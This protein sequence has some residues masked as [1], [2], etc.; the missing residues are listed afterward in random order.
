MAWVEIENF[1]Y[2]DGEIVGQNGGTNW[3]G[4]WTGNTGLNVVTNQLK[5]CCGTSNDK[6]ITRGLTTSVSSGSV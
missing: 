6:T 5:F 1:T 3:S 2:S 4:A